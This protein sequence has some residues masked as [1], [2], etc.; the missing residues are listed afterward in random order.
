MPAV[1]LL[2]NVTDGGD[3]PYFTDEETEKAYP[4]PYSWPM[5]ELEIY[6]QILLLFPEGLLHLIEK[7]LLFH[8]PFEAALK[9]GCE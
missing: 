7:T 2:S 5:M 3:H 1:T 8:L 9:L 4:R 6:S